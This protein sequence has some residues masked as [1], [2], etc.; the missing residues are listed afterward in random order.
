MIVNDFAGP[1]R[2]VKQATEN[3]G[4]AESH[5]RE[6]TPRSQDVCSQGMFF[7]GRCLPLKGLF[8][9]ICSLWPGPVIMSE[10]FVCDFFA[11]LFYSLS[12]ILL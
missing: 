6:P 9:N 1:G 5:M 3:N 11:I 8:P 7:P 4:A 10:R 12:E 2:P